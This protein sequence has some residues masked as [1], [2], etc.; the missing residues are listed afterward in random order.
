MPKKEIYIYFHNIFHQFRQ[1]AFE[2]NV[3]KINNLQIDFLRRKKKKNRKHVY[4]LTYL[5]HEFQYCHIFP[6]WQT[7]IF[8]SEKEGKY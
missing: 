1:W 5:A 7:R 6:I 8:D 2:K 4:H 3:N